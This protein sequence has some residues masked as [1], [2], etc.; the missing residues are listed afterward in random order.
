MKD[1]EKIADYLH[2]FDETV[3]I[4]KGLGEYIADEIL[5]KKVLR[6]LTPKYDT[7]VS[8]IEEAK[9]VKIF[10][11]DEL[12][13]SLIA[14]EVTK[15]SDAFLRKEVAFNT[16]KR[17][18]EVASHKGSSED[19]DEEVEKFV[20]KLKRGSKKYKGKLPLKCFNYGKVGHFATKCPYN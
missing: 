6:S 3:N 19:F 1:D 18:K 20:R 15:N 5:V 7:K 16:F 8:S 9:D 4:I 14:Y 10:T 11:M 13:G 17:D 2:I 12:F